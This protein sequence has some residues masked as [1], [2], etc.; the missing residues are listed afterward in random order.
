M[1]SGEGLRGEVPPI[2]DGM[3]VKDAD[4]VHIKTTVVSDVGNG[5]HVGP[6]IWS[7]SHESGVLGTQAA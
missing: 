7:V 6:S 3:A 4:R 2:K 1:D 5:Y